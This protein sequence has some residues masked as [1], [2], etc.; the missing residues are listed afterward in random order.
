[1]VFEVRNW[2]M[3]F[4]GTF[5]LCYIGGL[6]VNNG[7]T[8]AN[9]ALAHGFVLGFMI[10]AGGHVSGANYNPAVTLGLCLTNK[11]DWINGLFYM[12]FQYL[13]SFLAGLLVTWYSP[14]NSPGCP[15]GW[16]TAVLG[17]SPFQG[18]I[19]ELIATFFLV[20]TVMGTAIDTRAA[21]GVYGLCIGGSLT[22]SILGIGM[23]TGGALNPWRFFGPRVAGF[24][25]G[26][27]FPATWW[28]YLFPFVGGVGAALMYGCVFLPKEIEEVNSSDIEVELKI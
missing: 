1:M 10:Y 3:E 23:K 13:G 14:V 7:G 18:A 16:D 12:L 9:V 21:K 27:T 26:G 8:L 4:T 28:I 17:G 15:G 6:A 11:L 2:M 19:M 24:I 5:A 25:M 20:F 22:M